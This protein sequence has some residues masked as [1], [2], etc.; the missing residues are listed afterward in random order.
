MKEEYWNYP[1]FHNV[2]ELI[3]YV[4]NRYPNNNAFILKKKIKEAV[5]Y[6]NISYKEFLEDLNNFGQGLFDM[7]YANKRIGIIGKNRYEW[8]LIYF[9]ALLGNMEIVPLD[10][11]LQEQETELCIVRGKIDILFYDDS[12]EDMINS[13]RESGHVNLDEYITMCDVENKTSV[14]SIKENGKISRQNGNETYEKIKI[15][16]DKMS[17][18]CFTSGTSAASKIVM[19]SHRNIAFDMSSTHAMEDFR[20]TDVNLAFI[21]LHHTFGC[22]G[23]L[24]IMSYGAATAFPDG[25]RYIQSNLKEYGVTVFIGVPLLIESMY[26]KIMKEVSKQK[27]EKLINF[28]RKATKPCPFMKRIVFKKVI[29]QLGGKLRL[30][31]SGAASIDQGVCK[32][33]DEI[34]IKVIPG[35]GLTECSPVAIAESPLCHNYGSIGEPIR[36]VQAKIVDK[37]EQ[38]IGEIAIKGDNVMLGYYE[39]EEATREVFRD[40]WLLTGDLAYMDAKG[41]FYI[42]GRKKNVIIT[43]N[44]KN[45]YPEE[46]EFLINKIPEVNECMVYAIPKDDDMT[47]AVKVQY[48]MEYLKIKYPNLNFK[49]ID[50]VIWEKIKEINKGFPTYK[51]VKHMIATEE[52]F[53]KTTTAKIKRYEEIEKIN[54]EKK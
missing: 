54:N 5:E 53:I 2:K 42:T 47:L 23:V 10:K 35:Y 41:R 22:N 26:K 43:K 14:Y 49:E 24:F 19:L 18:L 4:V 27:K 20:N 39:N 50:K 25:L 37:N 6:K 44:G 34:G 45:I 46:I 9:S 28:M 3:Y 36:G 51:Y 48:D 15:D 33:F 11:G 1:D 17:V 30:M 7:G 31:I 12:V 8:V 32:F 16:N 13:I 21:P 29:S 38:G 52:A 40:G